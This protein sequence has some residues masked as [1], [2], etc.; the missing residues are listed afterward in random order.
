M[1]RTEFIACFNKMVS[2][3]GDDTIDEESIDRLRLLLKSSSITA[4]DTTPSKTK[5]RPTFV[6]KGDTYMTQGANRMNLGNL[7]LRLIRDFA[8]ETD[9]AAGELM[10][11][12][13]SRIPAYWQDLKKAGLG[14]VS[15]RS[16]PAIGKKNIKDLHFAEKNEIV[17]L[18]EKEL[19]VCRGWG[20]CE[21]TTLIGILGY[22]DRVSSNIM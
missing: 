1:E 11:M 20:A 15:D 8:M 18:G 5:V 19:I 10:D 9:K 12:I 16:N 4:T 3:A 22:G 13:N 21:L 2:H 17:L 7:A 14:Q 6:Y